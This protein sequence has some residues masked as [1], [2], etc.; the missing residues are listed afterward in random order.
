MN[1]YEL[2]W[3]ALFAVGIVGAGACYLIDALKFLFTTG[4]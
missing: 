1:L 2:F 3:L 4:D